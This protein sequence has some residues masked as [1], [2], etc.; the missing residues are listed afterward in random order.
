[1][2]K[3]RICYS[4]EFSNHLKNYLTD[5]EKKS[6]H[7]ANKLRSN[8]RQSINNLKSFPKLWHEVQSPINRLTKYRKIVLI[9]DYLIFYYPDEVDKQFILLI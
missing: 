3:Y 8:I 1:M 2:K 6:L 7:A 5:L 4:E 9:Y